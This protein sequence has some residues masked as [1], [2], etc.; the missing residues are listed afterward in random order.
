MEPRGNPE[1][2]WWLCVCL[3]A[4]RLY[5]LAPRQ[6]SPLCMASVCLSCS[7]ICQPTARAGT[8]RPAEANTAATSISSSRQTLR[9]RAARHAAHAPHARPSAACARAQPARSSTQ[10]I[11]KPARTNS[12]RPRVASS[13]PPSRIEKAPKANHAACTPSEGMRRTAA[14]SSP[15]KKIATTKPR[16]LPA[17]RL[18]GRQEEEAPRRR[19]QDEGRRRAVGQGEVSA[20]GAVRRD[21]ACVSVCELPVLAGAHAPMCTL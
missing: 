10:T 11:M 12:V 20:R 14:V 8:R 4:A 7:S 2:S 21:R 16:L 18:Q 3:A 15:P 19:H 17:H 1:C 9:R 6:Q 13:S 5:R